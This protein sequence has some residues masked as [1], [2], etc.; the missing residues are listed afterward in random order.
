MA[1]ATATPLAENTPSATNTPSVN[2]TATNTP[3]VNATNTPAVNP[4][5]TITP[6]QGSLTGKVYNLFT[7]GAVKDANISINGKTG[8]TDAGGNYTSDREHEIPVNITAAIMDA[9][10]D[11]MGNY[12]YFR[13]K[14]IAA[15]IPLFLP[16][17]VFP[18]S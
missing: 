12:F 5:A 3:S 10:H 8:T 6:A 11:S 18:S 16:M 14:D 2:A 15:L 7:N 4:A 9:G 1:Q 17:P 13:Q